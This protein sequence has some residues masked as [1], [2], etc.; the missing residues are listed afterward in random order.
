MQRVVYTDVSDVVPYTCISLRTCY[1]YPMDLSIII[2]SYNTKK[3]TQETLDA[4]QLSLKKTPALIYET[5]VVDN[6]STD[7]SLAMLKKRTDIRLIASKKNV[8]FGAGNNLG[9]KKAK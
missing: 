6:G 5:I 1:N 8:G 4:L 2:V 7:D 9:I 3:L